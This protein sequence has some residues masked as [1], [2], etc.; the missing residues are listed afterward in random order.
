MLIVILV[1]RY[2]NTGELKLKKNKN[3][4]SVKSEASSTKTKLTSTTTGLIPS[5]KENNL[6]DNNLSCYPTKNRNE[7]LSSH[8]DKVITAVELFEPLIQPKTGTRTGIE[9]IQSVFSRYVEDMH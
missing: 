6:T 1:K 9:V 5:L 7:Y 3:E 2:R 8:Q 4:A